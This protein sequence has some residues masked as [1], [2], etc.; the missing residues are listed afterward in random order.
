[1]RI[2]FIHP[3]M[4]GQFKHL[5]R[6]YGALRGYEAAFITKPKPDVTIPG[7][8]K[9]EYIEPREPNVK[10]HRYL[11]STERG[12][13]VGQEVYRAARRLKQGG[14]TPDVIV[15]HPGWGD[16]LFLRDLWPD[17]PQLHFCEFFYN[18]RGSDVG[19]DPE[20]PVTEDDA[21]RIRI[22]NTIHLHSLASATWGYAPT[23]W[24]HSQFPEV[25]RPSISVVHDGIDMET[26][27]PNE[28]ASFSLPDGRTLTKQ[29]KLV[30]Y[31]A[32]NLEPYRGIGTFMQAARIIQQRD[33]EV[34]IVVVGSDGVSYGKRLPA[35][36]SYRKIWMN[37]LPDLDLERLHFV[38]HLPYDALLDLFRITRAHIYL[39]YPFVLS[40]SMLEAMACGAPVIGSSTAPV[41]EVIKDGLNGWLVDFFSPEQVADAVMYALENDEERAAIQN[42]A[43]QTV[44]ANY[45]FADCLPK[46]MAMIVQLADGDAGEPGPSAIADARDLLA[47]LAENAG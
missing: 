22:K 36:Q 45:D 15:G 8:T 11:M 28:E 6:I 5:A 43:R 35:G 10:T 14:F 4:P 40:W 16:M 1:M 37:K 46:H 32:R 41:Q 34:R 47:K 26:C 17:V 9:V 33:P 29:D 25:F 3:N 19:F 38:G 2:L 31:V 20:A 12:V 21:A 7:V 42:A 23:H 44:Q 39:T 13:L 18:S 27:S 24:Q 30:T